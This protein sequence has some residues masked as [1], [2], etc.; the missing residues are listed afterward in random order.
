MKQHIE[1]LAH[2]GLNDEVNKGVNYGYYDTMKTGIA[3]K[4]HD[5]DM[6]T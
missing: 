6:L 2:K 1:S 4:W 5:F 3:A